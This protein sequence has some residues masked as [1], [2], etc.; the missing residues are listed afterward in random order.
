MHYRCESG[1]DSNFKASPHRARPSPALSDNHTH[2][3]EN[4]HLVATLQYIRY[5]PH[6]CQT[7]SNEIEW[8]PTTHVKPV[9]GLPQIFWSDY[10]PWTEA[11]LWARE[12]ATT[13]DTSIQTVQ[14]NLLALHAYATWLEA[15][16]TN[17]TDFPQKKADRC[18]IK[19]R[20]A[21]VTARNTG[22]IAPSTASARMSV[23]VQ[24]YRWLYM[25]GLFS[26]EAAMWNERSVGIRITDFTGLERTVHVKSTDLAIPNRKAPGA[27][28]EDGLLPLS[29]GDRDSLLEFAAHH[30]SEELKLMLAL[31]F[32][33]GMRIGTIADLKIQTLENAAPDPASK[34][35]F[36][37]AVGPGAHPPVHTK[38]GV[39][40]QVYITAELL[41][42]VRTYFYSTRRL[43][44]Q[45][46]AKEADRNVVFL[47]V[48]GNR[49]AQHCANKSS[50]INVELHALR[51]RGEASG[52]QALRHF[53]FHQS[54]ATY[55]T[56]LA[57]LAISV[58]GAI[59]AIALVR[60]ALLHKNESTSLQYIKFVETSP[61]KERANNAFSEAFLG[62]I[63]SRERAFHE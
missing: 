39:T 46:I 23:A 30:A 20:G 19:Y 56:E 47:T 51:K 48:R 50:A 29:V 61:A 25:S 10:T 12:R 43:K 33:S 13:G 37:L 7:A 57:R 21:L 26:P 9:D 6:R 36:R 60:E 42:A 53:H 63:R 45:S 54:R 2:F 14:A 24:F 55:A 15:S 52:V 8:I 59:N 27:R 38:S 11:N 44:R 1:D 40:G 17:W 41:N 32:F 3:P 62:L 35:L 4:G 58:A 34:E 18:L 31:G 16:G 28:L 22:H 49:Y 5:I